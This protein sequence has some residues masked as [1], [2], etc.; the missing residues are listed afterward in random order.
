MGLLPYIHLLGSSVL[1]VS[2]IEEAQVQI[3]ETTRFPS[4]GY[5]IYCGSTDDLRDEHVVPLAL[6]GTLI[7]PDSS[8]KACAD[9]TSRLELEVLRGFMLAARTVAGFATRRPKNR[10]TRFE[11]DA[12]IQGKMQTRWLRA[13]DFPALLLLPIFRP[14][15]IIEARPNPDLFSVVG[16]QPARFGSHPMLVARQLLATKLS[17]SNTI[18]IGPYT[19]FLAKIAY[20]YSVCARGFVEIDSVPVLPFIRGEADDG[21]NWI[22]SSEFASDPSLEGAT[23][24]LRLVS[25]ALNGQAL[26]VIETVQLRL[27]ANSGGP[28]YEIVVSIQ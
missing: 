13:K 8:C 14:P 7:L 5:C 28:G 3:T 20:S 27:F 2:T 17:I 15:V 19:R 12:E 4:V 16:V 22:G 1:N 25:R 21:A 6:D 18:P 24:T 10:P 9:M 11:L 26:E 23:H